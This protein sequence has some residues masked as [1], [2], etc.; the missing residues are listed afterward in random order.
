MSYRQHIQASVNY[1]KFQHLCDVDGPNRLWS[2]EWLKHFQFFENQIDSETY[3]DGCKHYELALHKERHNQWGKYDSQHY[4]M[5]YLQAENEVKQWVE[6]DKQDKNLLSQLK[7][8][9]GF[10]HNSTNISTSCFSHFTKPF[11][12]SSSGNSATATCLLCAE[13]GHQVNQHPSN[14]TKFVDRKRLLGPF[15]HWPAQKP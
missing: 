7:S 12:F 10:R 2:S 14:K 3:F 15:C 11:S 9:A 6:L 5:L 8:A 1:W 4:T 13:R